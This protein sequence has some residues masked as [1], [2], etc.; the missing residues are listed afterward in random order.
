MSGISSGQPRK[1]RRT[2]R[3]YVQPSAA[4]YLGYVED[5]ETPEMIMRKFQELDK[6]QQDQKCAQNIDQQ[7]ENDQS[8]IEAVDKL[9]TEDQ[10][11]EL[12]RNTSIFSVQSALA[13][14]QVLTANLEEQI[15]ALENDFF[16]SEEGD[17]VDLCSQELQSA[18]GYKGEASTNQP[19]TRNN[20]ESKS[21]SNMPCMM[22]G[23]RVIRSMFGCVKNNEPM[24]KKIE[25]IITPSLPTIPDYTDTKC[26][27]QVI[28]LNDFL[29]QKYNRQYLGI[30]INQGWD[31]DCSCDVSILKKMNLQTLVPSGFIFMWLE[32]HQIQGI[33]KLMSQYNFQYVE[34]LTWVTISDE[35]E[36]LKE[37]GNYCGQSHKSM[38]IF[39]K[40]GKEVELRHQRSPDVVFDYLRL[41]QQGRWQTP[42]QVYSIIEILLPTGRNQLMEMWA[43][44]SAKRPGW[45]HVI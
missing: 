37:E 5:D 12:F 14:N 30:L 13:N 29:N 3:Q 10:M 40:F 9:L 2:R 20:G 25:F 6:I 43:W 33:K 11:E 42:N 18:S 41:D 23:K 32:K 28:R 8:Q 24:Y 36:I 27:S 26:T 17:D 22:N 34:N 21:I 38:Y 19:R 15:L 7:P 4:H 35:N 39:R 1:Q 16:I 44:E 31:T 45:V